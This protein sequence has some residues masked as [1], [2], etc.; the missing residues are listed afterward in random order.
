MEP[1]SAQRQRRVLNPRSH[2]G[3][4]CPLVLVSSGVTPLGLRPFLAVACRDTLVSGALGRG[5]ASC[6]GSGRS[7]SESPFL[8]GETSGRTSTGQGLSS[9]SSGAS[10]EEGTSDSWEG[11][12][13]DTPGQRRHPD[14][15]QQGQEARGGLGEQRG[16]V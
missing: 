9:H 2:D 12:G 3:N 6:D 8:P 5:L 1:A 7:P 4:V 16:G 13:W 15:S 10:E 11:R 14:P